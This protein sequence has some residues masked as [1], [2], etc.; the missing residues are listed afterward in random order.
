MYG[1]S[2]DGFK[3]YGRVMYLKTDMGP[4]V[5]Y[6]HLSKRG[7]ERARRSRAVTRS[8]CP[9]TPATA[10]GR[11]C[12]SVTATATRTSS[13]AGAREQARSPA[14]SPGCPR[15]WPRR[16]SSTRSTRSSRSGTRRQREPS[17]KMQGVHPL[18]PGDIS[19]VINRYGHRAV[20]Q[21]DEEVRDAGRRHRG[22][23]RH[24]QRRR[25]GTWTTSR[26]CTPR[27]TGWAGATSG[28]TCGRS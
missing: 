6:A 24:R 15:R 28:A 5:L 23:I 14:S 22:L 20:R 10:P 11:T 4:E 17:K 1:K 2:Q 7:S 8:V 13:P 9:A 19:A 25:V 21:A 27:R 16:S 3:S 26:S 12:T 18:F